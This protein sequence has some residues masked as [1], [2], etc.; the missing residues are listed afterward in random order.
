LQLPIIGAKH[1]AIMMWANTT[2]RPV[3]MPTI[4]ACNSVPV[5]WQTHTNTKL[6][7]I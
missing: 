1:T 4:I 7:E 2:Q 5:L 6:T 3:P